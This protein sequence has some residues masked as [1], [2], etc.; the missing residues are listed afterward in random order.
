MSLPE[1]VSRT[2]RMNPVSEVDGRG[3]NQWVVSVQLQT[4]KFWFWSIDRSRTTSRPSAGT[5]TEAA[6]WPSAFLCR[7]LG[8]GGDGSNLAEPPH[9][10]HHLQETQVSPPLGSGAVAAGVMQWL[11]I[12]RCAH[13]KEQLLLLL[14]VLLSSSSVLLSGLEGAPLSSATLGLLC[15]VSFVH[16]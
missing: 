3:K 12:L 5:G 14:G 4:I 15:S 6:P 1:P 16:I 11:C 10:C 2:S 9:S 13:V 8:S 7:V